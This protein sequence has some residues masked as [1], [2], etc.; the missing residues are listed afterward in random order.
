M[1]KVLDVIQHITGNVQ[2]QQLVSLHYYYYY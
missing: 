2:P 1:S